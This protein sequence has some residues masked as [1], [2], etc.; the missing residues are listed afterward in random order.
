M[1]DA[2]EQRA[3]VAC[4]LAPEWHEAEFVLGLGALLGYY[5]AAVGVWSEGNAEGGLAGLAGL[6]GEMEAEGGLLWVLGRFVAGRMGR[7]GLGGGF[8]GKGAVE[9]EWGRVWTGG[10]V[11]CACGW[12]GVRVEALDGDA[13]GSAVLVEGELDRMGEGLA[14][15][16]D[17]VVSYYWSAQG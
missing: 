7:A 1:Q 11:V 9:D 12:V 17:G 16:D 6:L 5:G 2:H 3:A 13:G 10:R 15:T 14:K 8:G 4:H